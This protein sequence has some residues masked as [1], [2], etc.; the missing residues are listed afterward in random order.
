MGDLTVSAATAKKSFAVNSKPEL[1]MLVTNT[2]ATPCKLDIA[3][4][5]VE[6]RVYVGDA[7]VW[8]SHDCAVKSGS[9]VVPL[10]A[11]QAI[12]LSISWSGL[13]SA[14]KCA[15][16]RLAVQAGTYRL[17]AYFDG[18]ASPAA[19]FTVK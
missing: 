9:D 8:G 18:K 6:W 2:A 5:H 15:G 19:L 4:E 17:Y 13:T 10:T 11:H 1:S 12:R 7:R 3:D 14:P 16:T